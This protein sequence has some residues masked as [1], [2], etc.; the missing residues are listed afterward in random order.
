MEEYEVWFCPA[1]GAK[2]DPD[3]T[4]YYTREGEAVEPIVA[5]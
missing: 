4:V 3:G 1:C 5:K 2:L